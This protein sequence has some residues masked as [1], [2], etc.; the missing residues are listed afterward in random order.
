MHFNMMFRDECYF[1]VFCAYCCSEKI[2]TVKVVL[3]FIALWVNLG[4][5]QEILVFVVNCDL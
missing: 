1:E 3:F 5:P 4:F 2:I